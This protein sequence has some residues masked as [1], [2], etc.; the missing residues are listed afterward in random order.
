MSAGKNVGKTSAGAHRNDAVGGN[1]ERAWIGGN[2]GKTSTEGFELLANYFIS[3]L[4]LPE[5]VNSKKP[6]LKTVNSES[7]DRDASLRHLGGEQ[8]FFCAPFLFA[9]SISLSLFYS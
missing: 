9:F 6:K 2:L 1:I 8:N 5:F 4:S 7:L 3:D